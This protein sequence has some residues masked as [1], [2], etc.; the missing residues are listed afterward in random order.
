MQEYFGFVERGFI[1]KKFKKILAAALCAV[2]TFTLGSVSVMADMT[3]SHDDDM[4]LVSEWTT[5]DGN[6]LYSVNKTWVSDIKPCVLEEIK[7]SEASKIKKICDDEMILI[8][9]ERIDDGEFYYIDRVWVSDIEAVSRTNYEARSVE[10]KRE[11]YLNDNSDSIKLAEIYSFGRFCWNTKEN[12][13][14][15]AEH[16]CLAYSCIS[17]E[18]PKVHNKRERVEDNCGGWPGK[19][20][21][22][23]DYAIELEVEKGIR[24]IY[25]VWIDV[26]VDGEATVN[27]INK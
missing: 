1:M 6:G 15:V 27:E 17:Q 20:Y 3:R 22:V 7:P 10:H 11:I 12:D 14:V 2:M 24:Q 25:G 8:S 23:V 21:A 4:T 13:V 18:Y 16:Q 26:N 5:Y 9:E 19:K